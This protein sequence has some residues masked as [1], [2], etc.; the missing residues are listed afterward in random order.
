VPN[1][2]HSLTTLGYPIA[3]HKKHVE[4]A[5]SAG[6]SWRFLVRAVGSL[7]LDFCNLFTKG[8]PMRIALIVAT[9]IEAAA[10]AGVALTWFHPRR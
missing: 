10:F 4:P 3:R 6:I 2:A 9:L 7:L 8:L 1:I 5:G